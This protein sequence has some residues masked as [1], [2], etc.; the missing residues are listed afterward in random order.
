MKQIYILL[1]TFI[2]LFINIKSTETT[3]SFES[4]V[5][6]YTLSE[7]KST[8]EITGAGPFDLKGSVEN[9]KIIVSSSCTLN[10]EDFSL[11][12]SGPLTPILISENKAVEIALTSE[13][14]LADS[15]TNENDGTIYLQKGASLT[16]S[17]TGT[18]KI[19]PNK[20]MAINGTE[21]TSLTVND[22]ATIQIVSTL[23]TTGGIYMRKSITFNNAK[24]GYNAEKGT[25]HAIDSEGDI[26]IIKGQYNLI[27]GGGK[28][29][30]SEKNLYIGEENGNNADLELSITTNDEGI[31]AMGITLYSGSVS[32]SAGGDGINAAS[33]G[34][35]CG[36]NAPRCSGN[37]VCYINIKG[38]MLYLTSDEDGLDANGDIFISDGKVL[39]FAASD[40]EDQPI[41]QDGILNITGG[42][43][44]AAGSSKMQGGV[45]AQ[46]TQVAKIYSGSISKGD[47]LLVTDS[48]GNQVLNQE[49]PK[50][51]GYIYFNHASSFTFKI[52]GNEAALSEPT[53]NQ[54]QGGPQGGQQGGP[55]NSDGMGPPP[56][57]LNG[58]GNPRSDMN[59]PGGVPPSDLNGPSSN[60]NGKPEETDG[61]EK[62]GDN[63]LGFSKILCV[64]LVLIFN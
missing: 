53:Q 37:C 22:E 4:A 52:N 30:Q 39:V 6:G 27:S 25:H 1:A 12:N 31:E 9:K 11:I 23:T 44:I 57:D 46:T 59:G 5:D 15:V 49:S 8:V 32:I 64:F 47:A 50:A 62:E 21:G 34:D 43:I 42:S 40:T 58:P 48:N 33:A 61:D 60:L 17:G 28:G 20:L 36:D 56:S 3:I 45:N 18:L 35:E 54:Q 16:I 2:S 26:K 7:D 38:G 63:F 14:L 13:S 41:D 51:A 29:I 24:I 19:T 10:L 55:N